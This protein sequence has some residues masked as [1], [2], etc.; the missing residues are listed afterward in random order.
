MMVGMQRLHPRT[1]GRDHHDRV[2]PR[3]QLRGGDAEAVVQDVQGGELLGGGQ[4]RRGRDRPVFLRWGR[5][6]G[7]SVIEQKQQ[8]KGR[9]R[10][11]IVWRQQARTHPAEDGSNEKWGM[12]RSGPAA[13]AG[14]ATATAACISASDAPSPPRY[15]RT[16]CRA[17]ESGASSSPAP[18]TMRS[19]R[20]SKR[21]SIALD[22]ARRAVSLLKGGVVVWCEQTLRGQR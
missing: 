17:M 18:A 10:V 11:F 14:G 15:S 3:A 20:A 21:A 12:G 9:S 1:K 16:A 6:G 8:R 2:G 7:I 5:V 13:A 4:Q 22:R 19:R